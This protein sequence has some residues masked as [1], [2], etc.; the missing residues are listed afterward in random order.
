M[1]LSGVCSSAM[2]LEVFYKVV[3][4]VFN[5]MS[6][7]SGATSFTSISFSQHFK[8]LASL[9]QNAWKAS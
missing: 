4:K 3:S 2:M 1:S 6:V 7:I 9:D 5:N 8:N